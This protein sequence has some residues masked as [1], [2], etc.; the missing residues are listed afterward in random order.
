M[1]TRTDEVLI[2][3]AGP[4]GLTA[5]IL[6]A[7]AG[8][9][10]RVFEAR[11]TV[12]GRFNDDFQ[13]LENWSRPE[14]VLTELHA[15]GI[16]PTWWRRPYCGGVLYDPDLRPIQI[17]ADR[18]LFHMVRRGPYH[19]A[20]LDLA[21]L[22]Q[23]RQAG[24]EVVFNTRLD[25][26]KAAIIAT[27]PR[28]APDLIAAGITFKIE[29]DDFAGAILNDTLAPAGYVY[30]LFSEGQAT[31]ATVLFEKYS[32]V[33]AC[34]RRSM[35]TVQKLFGLRGFPDVKHWGGYGSFSV[36]RSCEQNGALLVGEAAGFQDFLFGFGIRNALISGQLAAQSI[37]EGRSYDALWRA[38]LLPHLRASAVNRA[39]Y[40]RLSDVAKKGF[41]HLAGRSSR[42]DNF[43][44]WLYSFSP[45]HRLLYPFVA[46]NS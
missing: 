34:M 29:R 23:A 11:S 3:G 7:R 4:A 9:R 5:A 2:A 16:A 17:Q 28:G 42:P 8:Y 26:A 27:G 31:L 20:S 25:P 21:L 45:V 38:R 46:P 14:D 40:G 30:F 19:P 15:A 41:W 44:R 32:E 24:V 13:G 10:A 35:E 33:H 36:P 1:T 6:L 43:M 12:G 18:P 22:E 37:I 39:V